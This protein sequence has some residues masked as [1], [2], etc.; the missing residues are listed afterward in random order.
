MKP[1]NVAKKIGEKIEVWSKDH[2][3]LIVAIDG[4]AGSGKTTVTN[5]IAK[6]NHNILIVHLD[7][8][9]RHW[10]KRKQSIKNSKDKSA[11]CEYNWYRYNDLE[12]L[13]IEFKKRNE[14]CITYKTYDY[15]KNDF[16]SDGLIDLSKKI[17]IVEGIFLFHPK[18]AINK[19]WNKT[20]YLDIDLAEA[21]K[22]RL[23]REKEKWG[24]D[25]IT[26]D[27]PDNWIQYY[28]QAYRRYIEEQKPQ[29]NRD[30]VI[31]I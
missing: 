14:G 1:E 10:R 2:A 30:L 15:D 22:R 12:K 19:L 4:C 17:M 21:D 8:F 9:I 20:I 3:K 6:Q 18:H 5:L 16:G 11:V 28:K 7:D 24:N 23:A 13:I 31:K 26:E 27:H 25:Y 29:E